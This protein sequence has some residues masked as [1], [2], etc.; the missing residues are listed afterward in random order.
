MKKKHLNLI[1]YVLL[2][3]GITSCLTFL[4]Y[5]IEK[6]IDNSQ[7][8]FFSDFILYVWGYG[9]IA[10]TDKILKTIF[11]IV[12][13]LSVSLLSSIITVNLL[14]PHHTAK[15]SDYMHIWTDDFEHTF[16]SI[17]LKSTSANIFNVKVVLQYSNE[18]KIQYEERY[19]PLLNNHSVYKIDF[20]IKPN[21]AIFN[22]A[23]SIL[24][25]NESATLVILVSYIDDGISQEQTFLKK[26]SLSK[27]FKEESSIVI[28][29]SKLLKLKNIS[30]K[31]FQKLHKDDNIEYT[32]Y[33]EKLIQSNSIPIDIYTARLINPEFSS[34]EFDVAPATNRQIADISIDKSQFLSKIQ[35]Q[36]D[37]NFKHE[38]TM[39][40]IQ[41]PLGGNWKDYYDL[42]CTFGFDIYVSGN[43]SVTLELKNSLG[44]PIISPCPTFHNSDGYEHFSVKLR[45]FSMEKWQD[46]N[47]ICFTTFFKDIKD[48]NPCMFSVV[49]CELSLPDA[50]K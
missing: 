30:Y 36:E 13:I 20:E 50:N 6:S 1:V 44:Q 46:V 34:L 10:G 16:G 29:N 19:I 4:W 24:K 23:R 8:L 14:Y 38:F 28:D 21:S 40:C 49:G 2:F 17:L 41:A 39:V 11:A 35:L 43:M 42:N 3:I 37:V 45:S 31:N 18:N 33:F 7:N 25:Y 27:Y 5:I 47:E 22:Y 15:L 32:S 48:N 9:D 26:Y 12:G